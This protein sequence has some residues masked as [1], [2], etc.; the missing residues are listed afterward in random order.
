[1]EAVHLDVV[2][3]LPNLSAEILQNVMSKLLDLGVESCGDL[4]LLTEQDLCD[5]MK[6]IQARKLITYFKS[7]STVDQT[8]TGESQPA[9]PS[10][11]HSGL[12]Q[13]KQGYPFL[14]S[15]WVESFDIPWD[16]MPKTLLEALHKSKRPTPRDR[17]KMVRVIIDSVKKVCPKPLRKH[18][19]VVARKVVELH[20]SS[21][22]DVFDNTVIGT[23]YDSLLNQLVCRVENVNREDVHEAKVRDMRCAKKRSSCIPYPEQETSTKDD[24]EMRREQE[25]L[26]T[27]FKADSSYTEDVHVLM[28]STHRLQQLDIK[29]G[30]SIT[31]LKKAWP[32]LFMPCG[33]ESHVELLLGVN[34]TETLDHSLRNKKRVILDFFDKEKHGKPNIMRAWREAPCSTQAEAEFL[35]IVLLTMAWFEEERDGLIQSKE[36]HL[37]SEEIERCQDTPVSPCII[38]AGDDIWM[39][40][41]YLLLVDGHVVAAAKTFKQAF[42]MLFAAYFC[43]HIC[44]AE[45]A[46]CT[47]EFIQRA[48]FGIN[49]DRGRKGKK[50]NVTVSKR[51][52][53]LVQRITECEWNI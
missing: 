35:R 12:E 5:V 21:F 19:A 29:L 8:E 49:P 48:F 22:K 9:T 27:M 52:L 23:G 46:S 10:R 16:S 17:R 28:A 24:A 31:E 13:I 3:A 51:V 20:P 37:S 6:P 18:L 44:Y 53:A 38:A 39:P 34:V 7:K 41:E 15:N 1:M 50:G 26:Q 25:A 11:A 45:K 2:N 4:C 40:E 43:F 30:T 32:F 33:L 14:N 47:L 36:A 42:C